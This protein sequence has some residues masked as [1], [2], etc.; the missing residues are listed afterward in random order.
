M[1]PDWRDEVMRHD[2]WIEMAARQSINLCGCCGLLRAAEMPVSG[3]TL[4]FRRLRWPNQVTHSGRI[5]IAGTFQYMASSPGTY[6][7]MVEADCGL[8]PAT[9]LFTG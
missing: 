4:A 5:L 8:D 2:R 1:P 7:E 6:H 3:P 9:L